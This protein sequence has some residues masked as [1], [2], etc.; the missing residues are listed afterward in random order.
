[1][2]PCGPTWPVQAKAR[3]S[4]AASSIQTGVGVVRKNR[5]EAPDTVPKGNIHVCVTGIGTVPQ[6]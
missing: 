6:L 3:V 5:H 1:M 4:I 2:S